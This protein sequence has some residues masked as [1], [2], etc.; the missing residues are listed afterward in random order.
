M[1]LTRHGSISLA[2]RLFL[3]KIM[4]T[5]RKLY[6]GKAILDVGILAAD[7]RILLGSLLSGDFLELGGR[8][9]DVL[10]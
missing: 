1:R 2:G 3:N 5:R 8:V 10:N 6:G 9:V 4:P 7:E